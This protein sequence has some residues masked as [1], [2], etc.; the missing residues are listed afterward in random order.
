MIEREDDQV[1]F[2][3]NGII[4]TNLF[5]FNHDTYKYDLIPIRVHKD[6]LKIIKRHCIIISMVKS[7]AESILGGG[8]KNTATESLL[9]HIDII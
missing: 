7:E 3:H 2:I 8:L 1:I 4:F 9:R 5:V 6:M